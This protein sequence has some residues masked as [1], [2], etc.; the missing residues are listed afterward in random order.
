MT[1]INREIK[2]SEQVSVG[3]GPD[4]SIG[5]GLQSLSTIQHPHSRLHQCSVNF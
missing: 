4:P 5:A 2:K 1:A 3:I